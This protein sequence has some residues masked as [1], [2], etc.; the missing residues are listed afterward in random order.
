MPR[1]RQRGRDG[2]G[3]GLDP[4]GVELPAAATS[5]NSLP[6]AGSRLTS[7]PQSNGK[8]RSPSRRVGSF[9]V[10]VVLLQN[11][12]ANAKS[13][14]GSTPRALRRIKRIEDASQRFRGNPGTIV[15]KGGPDRICAGS[16][17]NTQSAAVASLA[18]R[19]FRIQD[20]IQKHLHHLMRIA[21][22]V[23]QPG[24]AEVVDCNIVFSQRVS[25]QVEGMFDDLPQVHARLSGRWRRREISQVVHD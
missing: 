20:Q 24:L 17:P 21:L 7:R 23:R 2:R 8:Y 3:K 16:Q 13:Q 4:S 12:F 19:L 11:R 15:L 22:H 1:W 6:E 25:M 5:T 10:P 14:P 9:N 18:N